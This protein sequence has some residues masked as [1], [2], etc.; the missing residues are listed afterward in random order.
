MAHVIPLIQGGTVLDGEV[1]MHRGNTGKHPARPI[2]IVF[3]VMTIGP[4]AA[5]LH[6]PFEQRLYHLKK[7]SFRTPTANRNMFD[8]SLVANPNI[9]LPLVRKNF[10]Q[11]TELA[12]LLSKVVEDKG[13]RSYRNLPVHNHLTDGIIFQP[14]LPYVCGTDTNL[15]KWKYLDTVTIDV[16]LLPP[17]GG[18]RHHGDDEDM[19]RVGVMGADQT[20]VDMSRYVRLPKSERYRLEADKFESGARIAIDAVQRIIPRTVPAPA[21]RRS[22]FR[23]LFA[24]FK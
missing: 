18:H 19:L 4:S 12:E 23:R 22:W 21:A 1:V 3:D 2:F 14:N 11:R 20:T 5:V 16:E 24:W 9:A 13:A 6:L 17:G 7:A 10:V 8:D 15:L